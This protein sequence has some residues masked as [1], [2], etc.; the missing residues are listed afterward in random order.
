MFC[1]YR[2]VLFY[3]LEPLKS[4][5]TSHVKQFSLRNT[6][7]VFIGKVKDLQA[8]PTW[9]E[10]NSQKCTIQNGKHMIFYT[11]KYASYR[12]VSHKSRLIRQVRLHAFP[13]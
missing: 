2:D 13:K 5:L 7:C 9:K 1:P 12:I 11:K 10:Q 6:S 4:K 8:F 3:C